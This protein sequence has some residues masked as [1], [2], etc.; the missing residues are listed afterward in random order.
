MRRISCLCLAATSAAL[1]LAGSPVA[2]PPSHW[3]WRSLH[4]PLHIP[5]IEPGAA[6]P[7]SAPTS[8]DLGQEGT[9][10]LRGR[11]PAYPTLKPD[12]TLD[13]I[14]PPLQT[15]EFYGSEWSGQKVLWWV[16]GRYHGP[17]LIRGRQL[18]GPNLL[19]FDRGDPL[20]PSEIRI[21]PGKGVRNRASYTRL[22]AAGCYA[23][24]ID[25]TTFSRIIVFEAHFVTP[26]SG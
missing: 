5:R 11:G 14:Y 19:R 21:P 8:V 12:G 6:C 24:Q 17:V 16:S 10:L 23:Y 3:T 26:P 9:R 7:L 13:F 20:P 1:V 22:R 4:R 18:D 25:G 15:Q 2:A